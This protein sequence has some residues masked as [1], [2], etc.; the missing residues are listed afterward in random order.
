[1]KKD[2]GSL[3]VISAPSGAGKTTLCQKLSSI[4]PDLQHSVSY[5]TRPVRTGEVNNRDYTFVSGK[6]F[7]NMTDKGDFIEWAK[8]H[9][10]LY[11][12]SR[13]RLE[14]M[15]RKGISVILDIDTQGARQIRKKYDGGVYIFILPPSLKVLKERLNRRMSNSKQEIEERLMRAVEEIKDYK[16]YDYV[17]INDIFEDALEQLKSIVF[18][19]KV[20][21]KNIDPLWIKENFFRLG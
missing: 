13:K 10:H 12:T 2:K 21:T 20:R 18:L 11:G 14:E 7:R 1:M 6:V 4:L 19:E 5:T 9:G 16:K 8:V 3:F 15:L 17:I